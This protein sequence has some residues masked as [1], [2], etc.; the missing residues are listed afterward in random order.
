MRLNTQNIAERDFAKWQLEVGHGKHTDPTGSITLPDHFKCPENNIS[1]LIQTIYPGI[2]QLPLQPDHY[3]AQRTILTSRND[4]VDDINEALLA[5]FPGQER[6]FLSADSIKNDGANDEGDLL[7]P[8][9]YLNSINCSGLPLSKL[10]LKV[11]CPVMVLRNLNPG[12]GVCNGTRAVVTR[13]SNRVLEV[14]LLTGEHAGTTTFIP[15]LGLTPSNTQVPFEFCRRQFPVKVC[16][17]MTINKS[18][19]QSVDHVGLDLR[20]AVFTH[21]QL[22]VAISRVTSV[23]NIKAIWDSRSAQPVTKNIVYPEVIID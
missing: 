18:Q 15:R 13:L 4:D 21:G 5:Q 7:Y 3:F 11:G 1:S 12:E 8:V 2:D 16:F 14:R 6:E 19:G 23:H 17:A 10:K 20:N 22:Y 9:E